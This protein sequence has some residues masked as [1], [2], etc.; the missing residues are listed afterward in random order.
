MRI[1]RLAVGAGLLREDLR[2]WPFELV[3]NVMLASPL[4]PRL[5]RAFVL[6]ALGMQLASYDIY[7]RCTFR[8]ARLKVGRHGLINYGCHFDNSGMVE[9]GDG[10]YV[11]MG[12][13]FVTTTHLA[14]SCDCRAGALDVRP[15]TVGNG[16]WIGGRSVILPGVTIGDGCIVAAGSLVRCDCAPNTMYGGV[17]ARPIGREGLPAMAPA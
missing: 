10:V 8:S 15:I 9:L 17:P 4:V 2:R 16:T 3:A 1:K 5:G 7:P 11:G 14:G 13:T 6:R 12:V